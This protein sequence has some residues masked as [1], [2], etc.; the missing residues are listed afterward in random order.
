[1]LNKGQKIIL[2][3]KAE[4]IGGTLAGYLV[5]NKRFFE[6]HD[7]SKWLDSG[8]FTV[9]GTAISADHRLL[10]GNRLILNRP[11][12]QEPEVP[13]TGPILFQ[14]DDLV[15]VDKPSGIPVTP[16]GAYLENSLLHLLRDQLS[17][18]E[19][20]P[21]HRLDLETSGVMA[22]AANK[23]ARRHFQT[24]FQQGRVHKGYQALVFGRFN[25][26]MRLIDFP[27]GPDT[28]IYTRQ[29]RD[30]NGKAAQT[31]IASV[32][33]YADFS[34]LSLIPV[35]GRT[36]QLRAHLAGVGHSIVG[37]KKYYPDPNLYLDWIA[38]RDFSRLAPKLL[39]ERQALH[40]QEL[41]LL[42]DGRAQRFYSQVPAADRWLK[43]LGL[44]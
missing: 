38:F 16:T 35:S 44:S 23:N 19:I 5:A 36:N 21:I 4:H 15:I 10:A 17:N 22:F 7:V 41:E 8:C 27:L 13:G 1:M 18:P 24:Q 29:V 43:Q 20:S 34:L 33:H 6:G 32:T 2:P 3:L 30:P 31:G 25:P 39:L 9:D 11:P 42:V 28:L 40:C 12:W 26:Q 37:D 14:S